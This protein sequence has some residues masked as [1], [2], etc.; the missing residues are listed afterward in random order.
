[1]VSKLTPNSN[2]L[3]EI[4]GDESIND[5]IVAFGIA[6]APYKKV[7]E[8][9][10]EVKQVKSKFGGGEARIHCKEVLHGDRR[11]YSPWKHLSQSDVFDMLTN[12]A[13][14]AY[15]AGTRAW[16]GFLDSRSVPEQMLFEGDGKITSMK[17][18]NLHHLLFAYWAAIGP[19]FDFIPHQKTRGWMDPNRSRVKLL[20]QNKQIRLAQGFFPIHHNNIRFEPSP[21]DGEKPTLL[22]LA[23]IIAHC[24][25]RALSMR[26]SKGKQLYESVLSAIQPGLS[27]AHFNFEQGQ[28]LSIEAK[29]TAITEF[30]NFFNEFQ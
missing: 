28:I 23:D 26:S 15:N 24:S 9:N 12:I 19:I 16:I 4:F 25:A 17:V 5:E 2:I 18:T 14:S 10:R 11:K 1:M 3:F 13:Q 30:R 6:I 7:N 29:T 20:S 8:I 22:D 21:I 27:V